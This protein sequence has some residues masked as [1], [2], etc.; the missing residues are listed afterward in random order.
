M[1]C[2]YCGQDISP[3]AF[4]LHKRLCPKNPDNQPKTPAP[5]IVQPVPIVVTPPVDTKP[6]PDKTLEIIADVASH[7]ANP[8]GGMSKD[9][10]NALKA[11]VIVT[12]P[13]HTNGNGYGAIEVFH[14]VLDPYFITSVRIAEALRV[15]E[16]LSHKK[17]TCLL[18]TGHPGS[19]KTSL[20]L[21]LAAKFNR[22]AVVADMGTYQ[23]PQQLFQTTRL[24]QG[25]GDSMVTDVRES[26]FIKGLE[27]EGCVVVMDEMNRVENERVLNPLMP[28]LDKRRETWI[29]ELRRRVH[30]ADN[31]IIVATVNE[32][33]L[34][35]GINSLDAALR[36]RFREI[37][38]GYLPAE[39]ESQLIINKT[40]VGKTIA[41]SL[42]QF[43]FTVRNTPAVDK[44][45]S[46]RQVLTA[47]ESYAEGTTLWEAVETSIGNYNDPAWRQQVMEIFSLN[48]QDEAE[49]RRWLNREIEDKYVSYT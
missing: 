20:C 40:G 26:G 41:D 48:I 3:K 36:D 30:V 9:A 23:E 43:V 21:Q 29:E 39:Q 6:V 25:K 4:D 32:G 19:G 13:P 49:H 22:P 44:K 14:P 24:I 8:L 47:A 17:P 2:P 15:T 27:T 28:I 10:Q 1:N 37:N 45:I 38:L 33:A 46:T 12:K 34:F 11:T 5:V 42:A 16:A 31:V 7:P 18:V 35:C